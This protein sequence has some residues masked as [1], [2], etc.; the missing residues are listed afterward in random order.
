MSILLQVTLHYHADT[1]RVIEHL[2]LENSI[3]D[4][5]I[6]RLFME[7]RLQSFDS[8]FAG[9]DSFLNSSLPVRNAD[10]KQHTIRKVTPKTSSSK[11][12]YQVGPGIVPYFETTSRSACGLEWCMLKPAVS[13]L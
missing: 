4:Y 10:L 12:K 3:V 9:F 7:E 6:R 8:S 11:K 1:T 13:Q 2:S 5:H